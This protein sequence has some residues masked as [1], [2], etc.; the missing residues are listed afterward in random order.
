MVGVLI[1]GLIVGG[2]VGFAAGYLGSIMISK[3]MA[4]VG[5]AL[6]HVALPGLALGILFGFNPFLGAFAF[7][8]AT[9]VIT[10]YLQKSTVLPVESI[11]GV[12]FV[13]ALA[14]GILITPQVDLLEA[15]FGNVTTVTTFDVIATSIISVLVVLILRSIYS[16]LAL[17]MISRE[18]AVSN[19][20]NVDA[21]NLLYLL[22]VSTVVAVG[23]KEVG[24]LLVGAVVI[25]PAAAAR[26]LSS[27]LFR[28]SLL[29]GIFGVISAVAGVVVSG[30]LGL[31]AG[32]LVVLAGAAL[33][34]IGL[35]ARF[36]HLVR[37]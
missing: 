6:S 24:T 15:L 10:W 32:P 28:F 14:V 18:L 16:K 9:A 36:T 22:L 7:L 4:L 8:A 19:R 23:I 30:Y 2:F 35:A 37:A 29:S 20:I 5:D 3:R 12:L 25:V 13:L 31:P 21:L 1:P 17:T 27:S 34:V 26:N 33:F 11:I